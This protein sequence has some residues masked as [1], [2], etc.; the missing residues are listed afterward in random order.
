MSAVNVY[1]EKVKQG[2]YS[3]RVEVEQKVAAGELPVPTFSLRWGGGYEPYDKANKK[4]AGLLPKLGIAGLGTYLSAI[5][6]ALAQKNKLIPNY[7]LSAVA[8]ARG[9]L[10]LM[11]A[12][13]KRDDAVSM[14]A[15]IVGL[16]KE[17]IDKALSTILGGGA[18]GAG[19]AAG[20]TP[21]A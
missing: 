20:G 8:A 12:G 1:K 3:K 9:V 16:P 4:A 19:G 6:E 14:T 17:L 11:D 5:Y 13:A 15:E 7:W 10:I 2:G 18:A 21:G